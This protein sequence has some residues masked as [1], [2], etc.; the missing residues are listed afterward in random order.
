[1]NRQRG[2]PFEREA[3]AERITALD[4]AQRQAIR[5]AL[6]TLL[7]AALS[8]SEEAHDEQRES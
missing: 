4:E 3:T 6:K 7:E 8:V 2:F 5:A 1:M